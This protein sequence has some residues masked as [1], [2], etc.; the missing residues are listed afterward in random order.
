LNAS[1]KTILV[2]DDEPEIQFLLGEEIADLGYVVVKASGGVEAWG[3]ITSMPIDLIISDIRMPEGDGIDL[4][5]KVK[6]LKPSPKM[7]FITG[8]AAFDLDKVKTMGG[9]GF[10]F[11]PY[12]FEEL[13]HLISQVL[14]S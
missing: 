1:K 13:S 9:D 11:K 5:S 14:A 10:L 4:L 3:I 2:V 8:H 6:A 7:I 12:K